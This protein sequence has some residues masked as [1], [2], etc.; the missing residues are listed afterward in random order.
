MAELTRGPE[1]SALLWT[2]LI[3]CLILIVYKLIV[4]EDEQQKAK[5]AADRFTASAGFTDSAD[6]KKELEE[7]K[8]E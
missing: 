1:V 2:C 5:E 6:D 8:K 4:P 3:L 7:K